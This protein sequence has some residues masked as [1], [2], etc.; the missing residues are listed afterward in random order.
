[1]TFTS[2][3]QNGWKWCDDKLIIVSVWFTRIQLPPTVMKRSLKVKVMKK[4]VYLSDDN[5]ADNEE[6]IT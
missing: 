6:R 3:E 4:Y 5:L 2:S 1:M